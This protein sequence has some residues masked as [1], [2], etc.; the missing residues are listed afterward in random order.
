[1]SSQ[2][3]ASWVAVEE[4][5]VGTGHETDRQK[6]ALP[7][8]DVHEA[9]CHISHRLPS[10]F[11]QFSHAKNYQGIIE[12]P[13]CLQLGPS[14]SNRGGLTSISLRYHP[15]IISHVSKATTYQ[16]PY[17][18]SSWGEGEEKTQSPTLYGVKKRARSS[19][20]FSSTVSEHLLR[21]GTAEVYPVFFLNQRYAE[22]DPCFA[23]FP[24]YRNF[25]PMGHLT[26]AIWKSYCHANPMRDSNC[27]CHRHFLK[28]FVQTFQTEPNV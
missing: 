10:Y 7:R 23:F 27:H 2:L 19:P 13:S 9:L 22:N 1:M 16:W 26:L 14:P 8:L 11:D 21:S 6:S 24:L 17:S 18:C 12:P 25:T 5:H 3:I 4:H 20:A 15:T 28:S